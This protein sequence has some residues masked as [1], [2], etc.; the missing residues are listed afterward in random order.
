MSKTLCDSLIPFTWHEPIRCEKRAGHKGDHWCKDTGWTNE[1]ETAPELS[2]AELA[3]L[4]RP[5]APESLR[6]RL[7][8]AIAREDQAALAGAALTWEQTQ[9]AMGD[10]GAYYRR[11]ADVALEVVTESALR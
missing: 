8:A 6:E 7:A 5:D 11:L 2:A 4:D 10:G 1:S 9:A 3:F